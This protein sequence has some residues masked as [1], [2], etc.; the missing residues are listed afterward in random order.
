MVQ[1]LPLVEFVTVMSDSML[2]VT[3]STNAEVLGVTA[4]TSVDCADRADSA[5]LSATHP[6]QTRPIEAIAREIE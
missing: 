4:P 1:V 3:V 5:S 2:A 6:P